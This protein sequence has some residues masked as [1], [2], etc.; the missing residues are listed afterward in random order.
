MA[1]RQMISR[2]KVSR[3]LNYRIDL[4]AKLNKFQWNQVIPLR[5]IFLIKKV[6]ENV[7]DGKQF[8]NLTNENWFEALVV[9]WGGAMGRFGGGLLYGSRGV[10]N[11]GFDYKGSQNWVFHPCF[12]WWQT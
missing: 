10:Y 1:S 5:V 11:T 7:C 3:F 8:V 4:F 9:R 12:D 2:R 6:F